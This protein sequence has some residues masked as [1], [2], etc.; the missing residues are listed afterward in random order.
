MRDLEETLKVRDHGS[1]RSRGKRCGSAILASFRS[2]VNKMVRICRSMAIFG[3][4]IK[5]RRIQKSLAGL[6]IYYNTARPGTWR[7]G[8]SYTIDSKSWF[9]MVV[10]PI[11]CILSRDTWSASSLPGHIPIPDDPTQIIN[12][13][14]HSGGVIIGLGLPVD[15]K[16]T[17][18]CLF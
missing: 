13:H 16:S 11:G 3:L 6:R 17:P 5:I 12:Y 1:P 7:R 15:G 9:V 8:Y 14:Q 2:L 4:D 18:F 10:F